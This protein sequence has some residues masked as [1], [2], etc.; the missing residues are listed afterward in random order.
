MKKLSL[1]L[2]LTVLSCLLCA[3][4]SSDYK[5]ANTYFES[6]KYEEAFYLFQELGDYKDS[7]ELSNECQ[8]RIAKDFLALKKYD[9]A[10][11]IFSKI[12]QYKDSET[13]CKEC[14]YQKIVLLIEQEQYDTA[15]AELDTIPDY[16]DSSD[17]VILTNNWLAYKKGYQSIKKRDYADA[18]DVFS[19]IQGFQ[20]VDDILLRFTTKRMLASETYAIF[21]NLGNRIKASIEYEYNN[22]GQLVSADGSKSNRLVHFSREIQSFANEPYSIS[23]ASKEYYTYND[24]GT[25]NTISGIVG[26]NKSYVIVYNYDETGKIE[27]EDSTTNTDEG[28]CYYIYDEKGQLTGVRLDRNSSPIMHYSYDDSGKLVKAESTAFGNMFT[29]KYVYEGDVLISKEVSILGTNYLTEYYSYNSDG[30]LQKTEYEYAD[31]RNGRVE[32]TYRYNNYVFYE[33]A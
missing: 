11:E 29:M 12:P 15:L 3:C 32:I 8:Y 19:Q 30:T 14:I 25:I 22:K 7:I 21:D 27:Y 33:E 10:N 4:T 31:S 2:L 6:G 26:T 5:Q 13:L 9:E 16:K 1:G 18:Y 20:D 28:K 17:L 24:N 23:N